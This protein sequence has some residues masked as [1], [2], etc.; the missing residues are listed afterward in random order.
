MLEI[1][2]IFPIRLGEL[3]LDANLWQSATWL[4]MECT[5]RPFAIFWIT[6]S[7]TIASATEL[8]RS[9][10]KIFSTHTKNLLKSFRSVLNAVALVVFVKLPKVICIFQKVNWLNEKPLS[11]FHRS[12]FEHANAYD[13]SK[14]YCHDIASTAF[15]PAHIYA[16]EF[17]PLMRHRSFCAYIVILKSYTPDFCV[18]MFRSLA[19]ALF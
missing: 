4:F 16:V 14:W 10:W 2:S 6:T 19:L 7:R 15:S 11:I 8:G 12:A 17:F 3:T 1:I 13:A 5:R 9:D 18:S